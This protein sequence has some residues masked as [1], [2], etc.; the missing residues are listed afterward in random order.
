MT[1]KDKI[2]YGKLYSK[3][4]AK[5]ERYA[6]AFF[7]K[8][9]REQSKNLK[10]L[11]VQYP[12]EYVLANLN[13]I[14]QES[15]FQNAFNEFYQNAGEKFLKFHSLDLSIKK[16]KDPTQDQINSINISFRNAEKI[17]ELAK[18]A[19]SAEVGQKVTKITDYTRKII[20]ETIENGIAANKTKRDI[21]R[22]ILDKTGGNISK[23][24]AL[25]IA[26]TET[27]FISSKTAEIN[28]Q[29][30]PFEVIKTWIPVADGK[31]RPDHLAMFSH[32]SIPKDAMFNVGG[33]EMKY[34]GDYAGGAENCVN[35][36]CGIVYTPVKP[37]NPLI[38]SSTGSLL[39]NLVIGQILTEL[40]SN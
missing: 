10:G 2:A 34:P 8:T 33:V 38:D 15:T 22:G 32:K 20:K 18:I 3:F 1:K 14:I 4:N 27:T 36:R 28:I 30:S 9:L 6:L 31:T 12:L 39:S 35:C 26:R 24:R 21:A 17:A 25:T 13:T 40:F 16:D 5:F 23:E 37:D 11:M 19:Q 7:I 29:D